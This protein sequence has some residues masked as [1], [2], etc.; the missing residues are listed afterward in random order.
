MRVFEE[1]AQIMGRASSLKEREEEIPLVADRLRLSPESVALLLRGKPAQSRSRERG[2]SDRAQSPMTKL[3]LSSEAAVERDFLVAAACNPGRAGQLLAALSPEHFAD[4]SNR[5]VFIGLR[6]AFALITGPEDSEAAFAQLG[7][8]ARGDSDAGPLFVRVVMEADQGRYS[9][10]VL[11]EL[12]LRLQE[13]Q[14]SRQINAL[15]AT[16]DREGD[17]AEEQ[18][19]LLHLERLRQRVRASLTNLDPEE[20]RA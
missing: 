18:R 19:R 4:P 6:D 7:A 12:H 9:L 20:G 11:E 14:L 16:L 8:R 1:V 10:A 2:S 15:R 5:E 17:V 13:Q 3:L